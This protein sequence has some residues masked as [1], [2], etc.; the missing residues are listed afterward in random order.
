MIV[1]RR[2]PGARGRASGLKKNKKKMMLFRR[3]NAKAR[4]SRR[5]ATMPKPEPASWREVE[6]VVRSSKPGASN[7]GYIFRGH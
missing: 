5:I 7:E 3:S 2:R 4:F 1:G 6:K